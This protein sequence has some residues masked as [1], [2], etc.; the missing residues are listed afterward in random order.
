M[1]KIQTRA[2]KVRMGFL[3]LSAIL[4]SIS[5]SK[6]NSNPNNGGM[7]TPTAGSSFISVTNA[8]PTSSMYGV[9]SDNTNIYPAGTIG[10][11]SSTGI[12]NGSPYETI[13]DST[14]SVFLSSNG[15]R[16]NIDS[17]FAF[18]DSGYYSLF[19]YDTGQLKTLALRD[20]FSTP[21]PGGDADVRFL[22]F[23]SNSP[24]LTIQLISTDTA[25]ADS[26]SY[27]N[28]VFAGT[29][30][31][32]VDS[33]AMFKPVSAGTYKVLFNSGVTNLFTNDSV[34]F[35]AGKFYTL[36]VKGYVNGI[37]GTDSL[38]LGLTQNY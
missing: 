30:T 6:S 35:A 9:Y 27:N 33:L 28:I 17:S 29:T 18:Q 10:Y 32:T 2:G 8:S 16:T 22:N 15:T 1:K 7:T 13:S 31:T 3:G 26:V 19:V 34:T 25:N 24:A 38:G 5:C 23:S 12:I 20:N 37:N 36:Y 14:H 11:G 21:P 4:F